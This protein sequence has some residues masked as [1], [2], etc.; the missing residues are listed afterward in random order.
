MAFQYK[1]RDA[2]A[3][4]KRANQQGSEFAG[5]ID[6]DIK[7]YTPSKGDN[8]VRILPPT[9][10]GAEHYGLEVY[11]HYSVGPDKASVLCLNR[12]K[13][14][15]CPIC[16][17]RQRAERGGDDELANELK[18]GKRVLVWMLNRKDEQV[19]PM[20]WSMP[21][22]L[23]K[24]FT[25]L[26]RDPRTGEIYN[27]DD[28]EAGFDLSFEKTGEGINTKY[29]GT[30]IARRASSVDQEWVDFVVE[31]PIPM[32]LVWRD[33]DELK[34]LFEGGESGAEPQ[35]RGRDADPARG[36]RRDERERK[37]D[38]E[39]EPEPTTRWKP[40]GGGGGSAANA[41]PR[42]DDPPPA[43]DESDYGR[44]RPEAGPSRREEPQPSAGA[45]T[46]KTRAQELRE[47]FANR[48]K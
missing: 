5:I 8:F 10:E 3:W 11:V 35:G 24:D 18:P 41:A 40:R 46:G 47:K 1:R 31:L 33:Y 9:W 13:S 26:A 38:P 28:P 34:S 16:E 22:T 4:E 27:L 30:Q 7:T 19:G 14:E 39:P 42:E 36:A 45:T 29:V 23:D 15:R 20:I 2:A 6:A 21:W 32:T 12:M 37:P 25:K 17:A 43:R 44:E 48:A